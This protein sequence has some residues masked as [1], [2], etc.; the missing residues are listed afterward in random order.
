MMFGWFQ[1]VP[2]GETYYNLPIS[3]SSEYINSIVISAQTGT[4]GEKP[5]FVSFLKPYQKQ[6]K[7]VAICFISC[8]PSFPI[9][10][11]TAV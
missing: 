11:L 9:A 8:F 10:T 6:L 7:V 1:D 4:G 5:I 3:T 2:T